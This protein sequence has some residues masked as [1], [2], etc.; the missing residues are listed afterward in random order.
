MKNLL[1]IMTVSAGMV[2]ASNGFA[3]DFA[4]ARDVESGTAHNELALVPIEQAASTLAEEAVASD[5]LYCLMPFIQRFERKNEEAL[6]TREN[7]PTGNDFEVR[8]TDFVF[9]KK[10]T[11]ESYAKFI[12]EAAELKSSASISILNGKDANSQKKRNLYLY[13]FSHLIALAT[14]AKNNDVA[15]TKALIKSWE[16]RS[17][18]SIGNPFLPGSIYSIGALKPPHTLAS[19]STGENNPLFIAVDHDSFEAFKELFEFSWNN[20]GRGFGESVNYP[21]WCHELFMHIIKKDKIKFFSYITDLY[22]QHFFW[23]PIIK[24]D[25]IQI[26]W[27]LLALEKLDMFT[28]F[29]KN[30]M[31]NTPKELTTEHI[32]EYHNIL[33]EM[34]LKESEKK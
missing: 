7:V 5:P 10:I 21:N 27:K 24:L 17:T 18:G 28:L 11:P 25:F 23:R 9:D 1:K 32:A 13:S 16:S 31:R 20:T 2:Y 4:D 3:S 30:V 6:S 14:C 22:N 12:N 33:N 34:K 15:S 26:A 19:F 8:V 29:D